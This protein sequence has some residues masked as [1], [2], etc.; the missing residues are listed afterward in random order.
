MSIFLLLAPMSLIVA[1][2]GLAGFL[3]T[4]FHNQYDDPMGDAARILNDD[5]CPPD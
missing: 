4:V 1:A 2:I 5:D 3:W